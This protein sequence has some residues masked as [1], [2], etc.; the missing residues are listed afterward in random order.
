M[1]EQKFDELFRE[2][3]A[4]FS[5]APSTGA[6][7]QLNDLLAIRKRRAGWKFARLAAAIL[8]VA[9]S[10]Y[11]IHR[12]TKTAADDGVAAIAEIVDD[13]PSPK[14]PQT[15]TRA[16]E[17]ADKV[18][19]TT[20]SSP[21][22]VPD[23]ESSV[24]S[25]GSN[26]PQP[27]NTANDAVKPQ[28]SPLAAAKTVAPEP[29][30]EDMSTIISEEATAPSLETEAVTP[31]R[32]KVTITYKKS[33]APPDPTLAMTPEPQQKNSGRLKRIW[34]NLNPG[35]ISLAGFRATKDQILVINKRAK[36]SK[37]N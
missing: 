19:A 18:E 6:S 27:A 36:D 14:R 28:P 25:N 8:L 23:R 33:A 4:N 30:S 29:S 32:Q 24:A 5:Q 13:S 16:P 37:S 20:N 2:K 22:Q 17:V 11:S 15:Q 10:V 9:V 3:L 12:W 35:D 21:V 34:K 7:N 31:K 1:N 26:K